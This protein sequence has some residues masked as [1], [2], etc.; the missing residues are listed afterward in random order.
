MLDHSLERLEATR[1]TDPA[2]MK[3][4]RDVAELALLDGLVAD[5]SAMRVEKSAPKVESIAMSR[6]NSRESVDTALSES[7]VA[8]EL[9]K[10]DLEVIRVPVLS[11]SARCP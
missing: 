11:C 2:R 3:C 10:P 6:D 4:D 7:I 9:S 8:A 1:P 5:G